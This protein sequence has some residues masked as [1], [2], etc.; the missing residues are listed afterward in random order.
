MAE[1]VDR[2]ETDRS[3]DLV[4]AVQAALGWTKPSLSA[5]GVEVLRL[6]G[7]GLSDKEIARE[8]SVSDRTVE[9]HK[10]KIKR[11]D[12]RKEHSGPAPRGC[13]TFAALWRRLAPPKASTQSR[14]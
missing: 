3:H 13:E 2:A 7:F 8:L 1:G 11:K 10:A 6:L 9:S 5:R 14:L 12:R 4:S